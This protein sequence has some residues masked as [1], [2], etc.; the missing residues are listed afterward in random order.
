MFIC[1]FNC[2]RF[3]ALECVSTQN[4]E[5]IFAI[6]GINSPLTA[7]TFGYDGSYS[8]DSRDK[9]DGFEFG[10]EQIARSIVEFLGIFNNANF[11]SQFIHQADKLIGITM[12]KRAGKTIDKCG[13]SVDKSFDF[14]A[15]FFQRDGSG[16]EV[17]DILL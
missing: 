15:V 6:V 16:I 12:G 7:R 10:F 13:L 8:A 11:V 1:N 9:I 3:I 14:I 2:R 17:H 4:A 5:S